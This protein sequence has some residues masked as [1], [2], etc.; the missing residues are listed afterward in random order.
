MKNLEKSHAKQKNIELEWGS[1][2]QPPEPE[3]KILTTELLLPGLCFLSY[4]CAQGFILLLKKKEPNTEPD[5]N[6]NGN[7]TSCVLLK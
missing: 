2:P 7:A 3:V 5:L 1:N 4:K 6:P